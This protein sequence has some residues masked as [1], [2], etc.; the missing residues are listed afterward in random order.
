ML[1]GKVKNKFIK[2]TL[3]TIL[4]TGFL[5]GCFPAKNEFGKLRFSTSRFK[6]KPNTN[7]EYLSVVDTSCFYVSIHSKEF[8]KKYNLENYVTG[9]KFY[10]KGRVGIFKGIDFSKPET[11]NP[12][13]AS[14]CYYNYSEK[15]FFIESL[16]PTPGGRHVL[17]KEKIIDMRNDS[18]IV[19]NYNS[20][21]SYNDTSYYKKTKLPKEFL[22]YNPDW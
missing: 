4:T 2:K 15:G 9:Y 19:K 5:F 13:R 3:I 21:V 10:D 6:L 20:S 8:T 22:K 1:S 11:L 17:T 7:L 16:I 18:L 14:M 12:K